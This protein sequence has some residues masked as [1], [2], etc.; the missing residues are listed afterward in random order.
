MPGQPTE[1][2]VKLFT[3]CQQRL[4]AYIAVL[5]GDAEAA[6]DVLQETN[7]VLWQKAGDFTEGT[8][9]AA[10][11]STIARFQALAYLRNRRRDRH[12]FDAEIISELAVAAEHVV[13][14]LDERFSALRH[15]LEK[16]NVRHRDLLR[17]RYLEGETIASTAKA[18]GRTQAGV[19]TT[20]GR[21]RRTLLDCI[22]RRL[23]REGD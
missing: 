17:V 23:A 8:D 11:S 14:D 10:W 20:L 15:C 18:A 5:L 13:Q 22:Q 2:F 21:V 4:Y 9:F 3:G 16:L 1:Q 7:L 19:V 12:Q 6:N